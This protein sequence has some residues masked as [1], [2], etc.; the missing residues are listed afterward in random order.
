MKCRAKEMITRSGTKTLLL[1]SLT[2][3]FTFGECFAQGEALAATSVFSFQ[4]V[5]Q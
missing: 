5:V 2:L 3:F 1:F 4:S